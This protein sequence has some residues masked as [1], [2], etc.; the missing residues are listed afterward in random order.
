MDIKQATEDNALIL[1]LAGRLNSA[2]SSLLEKQLKSL[3]LGDH[4]NIVLDCQSLSYISSAGLRVFLAG[5]KAIGEKKG[6]MAL[7]SLS[8]NV[9]EVFEISGFIDILNIHS[10]RKQAVASF[11]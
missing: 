5:A 2:S 11:G 3:A 8:P 9:Q 6:Q 4:K 1:E 10:D 7:C